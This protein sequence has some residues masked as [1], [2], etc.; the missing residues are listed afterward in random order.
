MDITDLILHDHH[1]QRR[2]FAYLD[3][4]DRSNTEALGAVWNRLRILLEVH[5]EAEEQL[6]YPHLLKIGGGAGGE[7]VVSEVRDVI[8][9]HNDI[10]DAAESAGAQQ[11]GSDGW[12]QAVQNTNKA[13]SDHMAEE[14]REDLVDFRR[15]AD[16]QLRHDI[17]VAFATFE[18]THRDGVPAKD[19]DPDDYI[20]QNR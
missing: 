9:D 16:W 6:F 11:V 3:D 14:E 2:L 18:A 19:K 5:A 1:E 7:G 20:R 8:K 4:I 13:N 12:W 15:H 10:R 17:A